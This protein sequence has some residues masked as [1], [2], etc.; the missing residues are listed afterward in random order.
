MSQY[1]VLK[2]QRKFHITNILVESHERKKN[3]KKNYHKNSHIRGSS[4]LELEV[5]VLQ[6]YQSA[7]HR[8]VD[9]QRRANYPDLDITSSSD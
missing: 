1:G 4:S 7:T 9:E 5:H 6:D 2:P 8:L 3:S